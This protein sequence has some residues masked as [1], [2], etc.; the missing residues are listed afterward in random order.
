MQLRVSD[1]SVL[2]I[3]GVATDNLRT[4]VLFHDVE[5]QGVLVQMENTGATL[6]RDW[7]ADMLLMPQCIVAQSGMT[8]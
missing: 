5:L 8:K 1:V 4:L 6:D 2:Q 3:D 7:L